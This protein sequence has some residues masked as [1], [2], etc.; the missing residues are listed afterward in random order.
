MIFTLDLD[1]KESRR[2]KNQKSDGLPNNIFK[3]KE[4][5]A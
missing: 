3:S 5:N 4:N 2:T 1:G